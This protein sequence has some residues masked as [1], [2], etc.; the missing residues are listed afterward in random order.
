MEVVAL[1]VTSRSLLTWSTIDT[2]ATPTRFHIFT[3]SVVL[4]QLGR[5]DLDCVPSARYDLEVCRGS[6][7][8]RQARRP[9]NSGRLERSASFCN[10]GAMFSDFPGHIAFCPTKKRGRGNVRGEV[11]HCEPWQVLFLLLHGPIFFS[12]STSNHCSCACSKRM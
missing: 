6:N 10:D 4:T 11:E 7:W 12:C 1:M 3:F 8:F 5:T 2:I 9:H